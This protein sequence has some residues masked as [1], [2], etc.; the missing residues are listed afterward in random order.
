VQ[1]ANLQL[2]YVPSWDRWQG[3]EAE[4]VVDITY[5]AVAEQH[6]NQ[7]LSGYTA[8]LAPWRQ[9]MYIPLGALRPSG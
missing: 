9:S 5:M 7:L 3:E 2:G 8:T 6:R 4:R 1:A